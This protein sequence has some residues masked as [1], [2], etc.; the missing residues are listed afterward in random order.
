[1]NSLNPDAHTYPDK[2]IKADELA[3]Y[4]TKHEELKKEVAKIPGKISITM[5]GWTSKNSLPFMAIRGHWSDDNWTYQ[6]RLFDFAHVDGGHDGQNHSRIFT[7]CLA[8]LG[9]AFSKIIAITLDNA[10]NNDTFFDWLEEHG[11]LAD[12]HQARCMAHIIN[13]GVQDVLST[14]KVPAVYHDIDE[15]EDLDNEVIF[16]GVLPK[17]SRT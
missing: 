9:I 15:N 1:M 7:N 10:T 13:L 14:L 16:L 11:I 5:D 4:L 8:R 6:T 12:S 3:Y 2:T 17:D